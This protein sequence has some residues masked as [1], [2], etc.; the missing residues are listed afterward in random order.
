MVG[1]MVGGQ[2]TPK[3]CRRKNNKGVGYMKVTKT[4]IRLIG[5]TGS[6]IALYALAMFIITCVFGVRQYDLQVDDR[7]VH[8][9]NARLLSDI[10]TLPCGLRVAPNISAQKILDQYPWIAS[11]SL[12]RMPNNVMRTQVTIEEPSVKVN[13][14]IITEHLRVL[15]EST[16]MPASIA[17][18]PA[19][20]VTF[21][22]NVHNEIPSV[23]ISHAKTLTDER[24]HSYAITWIDEYQARLTDK[25]QPH[26]TILFNAYSIPDASM[27]AY[28][29]SIKRQLEERGSFSG[30][31][32]GTRW[33]ADVR[34][35]R[36]I[37]VFSEDK[38]VTR[39]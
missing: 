22:N 27:F 10:Q 16:F 13:T 39:G 33:V 5:Y 15:P 1:R 3:E 2:V 38:G 34:F 12:R 24:F 17:Q 8:P 31:Y 21:P 9:L 37:I 6:S 19:L 18:I 35:D 7:I 4:H 14:T 29:R 32:K 26:F 11:I 25:E 20:S 30:R 28:C 23:F 36:Q